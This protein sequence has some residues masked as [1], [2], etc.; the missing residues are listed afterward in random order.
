MKRYIIGVA[1][2]PSKA[3]LQDF[4]TSVRAVGC[5]PK[6]FKTIKHAIKFIIARDNLI[7]CIALSIEEIETSNIY[8][9]MN[10]LR[11][12]CT[13][14]NKTQP[15]VMVYSNYPLDAVT[16]RK[17]TQ[18]GVKGIIFVV[19]EFTDED[20]ITS[21]L[22]LMAGRTYLHKAVQDILKPARLKLKNDNNKTIE[23]TPRQNQVLELICTRGASNKSIAR[24]LDI[25]ESTVKLHTGAILKKY[26]LTNRTQ[27]ALFAKSKK[28]KVQS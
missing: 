20:K 12:L 6:M 18:A 14:S 10:T 13:M 19:P 1:D 24:L 25:S 2:N 17:L 23:L 27:L 8:D 15:P 21:W 28:P 9:I 11:T 5:N 7:E 22:E 16:I 4:D 3:N 26:G